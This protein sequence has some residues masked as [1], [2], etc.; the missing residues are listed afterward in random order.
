MRE[1]FVLTIV[2]LLVSDALT[3]CCHKDWPAGGV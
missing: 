2:L 3:S 1:Q